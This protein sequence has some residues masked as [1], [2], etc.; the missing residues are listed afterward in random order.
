M[1]VLNEIVEEI[2]ENYA[3][4]LLRKAL[5]EESRGFDIV[6]DDG[7]PGFQSYSGY[8][9]DEYDE[10]YEYCDDCDW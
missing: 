7:S 5:R 8:D 2:G 10:D 9:Q 3:V 4:Y 6:V 1:N